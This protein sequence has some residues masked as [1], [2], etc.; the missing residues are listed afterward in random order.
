MKYTTLLFFLFAGIVS[1][2]KDGAIVPNEPIKIYP[3][4]YFPVY[5]GSYWKYVTASNDTVIIRSEYDYRPFSF[6]YNNNELLYQTNNCLVPL[7]NNL[8]IFGYSYYEN[9]KLIPILATTLD[10]TWIVFSAFTPFLEPFFY[11]KRIVILD[12][13]MDIQNNRYDHVIK[14]VEFVFRENY[15]SYNIDSFYYAKD[16]GL[17]KHNTTEL[18]EYFIDH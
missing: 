13:I 7:W 18:V 14:I 12:T 16:V 15:P 11:K 4:P 1:C 5:P 6:V 3:L 9:N 8:Y 17:I 10:S 2:K